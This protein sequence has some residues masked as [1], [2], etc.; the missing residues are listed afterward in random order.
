M[1]E[2]LN[3]VVARIAKASLGGCLGQKVNVRK[4]PGGT[5]TIGASLHGGDA[6]DF[7]WIMYFGLTNNLRR[8]VVES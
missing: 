1:D 6:A 5:L 3:L 2:R 7:I 8:A 4:L